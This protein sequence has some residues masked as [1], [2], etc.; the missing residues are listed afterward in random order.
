MPERE[1]YSNRVGML[2]RTLASNATPKYLP[3]IGLEAV[4][5]NRLHDLARA[6]GDEVRDYELALE[7]G[8]EPMHQVDIP[9]RFHHLVQSVR[10]E[11]G[12]E[13]AARLEQ[14]GERIPS[15]SD[16]SVIDAWLKVLSAAATG[17][18]PLSPEGLSLT[19]AAAQKYAAEIK[20]WTQLL[21]EDDR[22]PSR[23]DWPRHMYSED[24]LMRG[25]VQ[26][27]IEFENVDRF[28]QY[29]RA[30]LAEDDWRRFL[31]WGLSVLI[32]QPSLR[33]AWKRAHGSH[34]TDDESIC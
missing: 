16:A 32:E 3:A 7:R 1:R 29:V 12:P 34:L 18:P 8:E 28:R 14:W 4:A 11:A 2:M 6:I 10:A 33:D 23:L 17:S 30:G 27:L 31:N 22:E 19:K 21:Q 15:L 20:R 26:S 5:S 9:E 24:Y 13:A 25:F